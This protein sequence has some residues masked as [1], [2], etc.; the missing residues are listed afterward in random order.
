MTT[1]H[2]STMT[3]LCTEVLGFEEFDIDSPLKCLR[4]LIS[5]LVQMSRKATIS[6]CIIVIDE[7]HSGSLSEE[8]QK[9]LLSNLVQENDDDGDFNL[10]FCA[11]PVKPL[12][13]HNL[14][15]IDYLSEAF[16][17][18]KFLLVYRGSQKIQDTARS[19]VNRRSAFY[20]DT[21]NMQASVI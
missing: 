9:T 1:F 15:N 7:L 21:H 13:N 19:I 6:K 3:S 18:K 4:S 2:A 8:E 14:F 17:K 10:I 11:S 12:V 20:M 5:R 16:Y